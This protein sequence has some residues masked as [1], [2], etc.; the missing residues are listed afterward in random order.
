MAEP[1]EI[2]TEP[3]CPP[4][5]SPDTIEIAPEEPAAAVPVKRAVRPESPLL[6]ASA[7]TSVIAPDEDTPPDPEAIDTEPP[8]LPCAVAAPASMSTEPG[9]WSLDPALRRTLPEA[10]PSAFPESNDTSP[11]GPD[12]AAPVESASQPL[13]PRDEASADCTKTF[14]DE[15]EDPDPD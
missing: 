10:P 7:V 9:R 13:D 14:P 4:L 15:E 6:T 1:D 2:R 3:T 12:A 11:E 5:A 8:G